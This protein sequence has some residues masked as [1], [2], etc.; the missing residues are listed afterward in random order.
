MTDK[1]S[2]TQTLALGHRINF[3]EEG[4]RLISDQTVNSKNGGKCALTIDEQFDSCCMSRASTKRATIEWIVN[5]RRR[6][7]AGR[8]RGWWEPGSVGEWET[9]VQGRLDEG[10]QRGSASP[11]L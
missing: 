6:H 3:F 2:D 9:V 7:K 5:E 1:D 10:G 4:W 11:N 8:V